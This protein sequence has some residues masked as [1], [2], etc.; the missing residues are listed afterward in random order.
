MNWYLEVLKKYAVFT[1]RASR[2]EYWM[3]F[4]VNII[5]GLVL[6]IAGL[7]IILWI[8]TLA[9]FLPGLGVAIRRLHD[10]GRSGWWLLIGLIPFI[11]VV[12]LIIFMVMDSEPGQNKYGQNPKGLASNDTSNQKVNNATQEPLVSA[13]AEEAKPQEEVV[14]NDI[15]TPVQDDVVVA[16]EILEEKN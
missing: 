8:Y 11:G 12:V 1:G 2:T 5:I 14:I 10:T 9:V 16:P 3:Y 7:D 13:P 15:P 6:S 4:L